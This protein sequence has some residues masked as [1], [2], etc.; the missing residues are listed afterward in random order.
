MLRGVLVGR[1][2]AAQGGTACLAR[3]QVYP[4]IA[5]LDAL[6]AFVSFL[7]F[8]GLSCPMS[9]VRANFFFH[10]GLYFCHGNTEVKV[11][12]NSLKALNFLRVLLYMIF[13]VPPWH[14]I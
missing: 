14:C 12:N 10:I 8:D 4:L 11:R 9:E 2:I 13:S 3:A 1:G 7:F 6:F 5:R